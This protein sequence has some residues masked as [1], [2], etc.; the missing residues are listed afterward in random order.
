MVCLF[1]SEQTCNKNRKGDGMIEGVGASPLAPKTQQ[2]QTQA[3]QVQ[4]SE[5]EQNV[6]QVDVTQKA[7]ETSRETQ[8][9]EFTVDSI[10][11]DIT[12]NTEQ[13]NRVSGISAA[14]AYQSADAL[15]SNSKDKE[16]AEG[17]LALMAGI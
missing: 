3:V 4:Q 15:L 1:A 16:S 5:P 14:Q 10:A 11:S 17:S 8:V 12:V 7:Q 9:R 13:S 6:N 2:S